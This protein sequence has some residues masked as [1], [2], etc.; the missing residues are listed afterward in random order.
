MGRCVKGQFVITG[1]SYL[2]WL[3]SSGS[4][5]LPSSD[6]ECNEIAV[7]GILLHRNTGRGLSCCAP[8]LVRILTGSSQNNWRCC[9]YAGNVSKTPKHCHVAKISFK[10]SFWQWFTRQCSAAALNWCVVDLSWLCHVTEFWKSFTHNMIK[11]WLKLDGSLFGPLCIY[12]LETFCFGNFISCL[13]G[14]FLQRRVQQRCILCTG[15]RRWTQETRAVRRRTMQTCLG[16]TST[17]NISTN[18]DVRCSPAADDV[19]L[20]CC[21]VTCCLQVS[22]SVLCQAI[23]KYTSKN[24]P[25]VFNSAHGRL[26]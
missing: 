26:L 10:S 16:W 24:K 20:Y 7:F 15:D 13:N 23:I 25:G 5:V 3:L 9:V 4:P 17:R 11:L 6:W 8:Q 18:V 21:L 1:H 14:N 19:F 2:V 22:Y 12:L